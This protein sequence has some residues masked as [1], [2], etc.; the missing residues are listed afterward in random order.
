MQKSEGGSSIHI[1]LTACI[2]PDKMVNTELQDANVRKKQYLEAIDFYLKETNCKIIFCENTGT[3]IFEEISSAE[4]YNRLE[5]LTFPGNDYDKSIGKAYGEG[6]IIKY[7]IEHAR[8]LRDTDYLIKIT[9]RVKILNINQM[10]GQ[11]Q[12]SVKTKDSDIIQLELSGERFAKSVCFA[13]PATW[14]LET[15][16]KYGEYLSESFWFE[17]MLYDSIEESVQLKIISCFPIID[18]ICGSLNKQYDYPN[19]LQRMLDHYGTLSVINKS[20][21]EWF[22]YIKNRIYWFCYLL[23]RKFGN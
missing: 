13:A 14:L 7:A 10:I 15:V 18:G 22:K 21:K 6:K 17:A 2:Y 1:L 23:A 4:K 11:L 8:L 12:K 20:R 16:N 19:R 5:Y 9:G 3:D